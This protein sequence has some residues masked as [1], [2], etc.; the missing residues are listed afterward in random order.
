MS[1]SRESVIA[2]WIDVVDASANVREAMSCVERSILEGVDALKLGRDVVD[3]LSDTG[4]K[5]Q[6]K[7]LDATWRVLTESRHRFRVLLAAYCVANGRDPEEV[8]RA[9]GIPGRNVDSLTRE[10]RELVASSN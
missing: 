2:A 7:E 1:F 3:V 6:R 4:I 5:D 10:A 8:S 9:W